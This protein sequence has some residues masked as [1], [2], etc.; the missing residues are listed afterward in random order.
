MYLKVQEEAIEFLCEFAL[1]EIGA[2][3]FQ[4]DAYESNSQQMIG[5]I[6]RHCVGIKNR[7]L[8]LAGP[9]RLVP[10][11]RRF[12]LRNSSPHT[13][14]TKEHATNKKQLDKTRNFDRYFR[15]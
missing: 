6:Q 5:W 9:F 2:T 1:I 4:D 3:S 12:I 7:L 10:F 14:Y 13:F 8:R 15:L 11:L